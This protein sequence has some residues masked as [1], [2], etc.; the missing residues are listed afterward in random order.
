MIDAFVFAFFPMLVAFAG[1]SDLLTMKIGN[2]VSLLLCV[3]FVVL[4]IAL[5]LPASAWGNHARGLLVIFIPCFACF[6]AGWM[7]GGDAKL[8][9]AVGLWFG[10]SPELLV[11][12][13]FVAVYGCALTLFILLARHHFTVLPR[14]LAGQEWLLRLQDAKSGIPY[15]IAISAAA[16]QTYPMTVWFAYL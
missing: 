1:A 12:L 16:L 4:G 14:M 7:G 15:G 5:G 6:A 9:S 8:L 3:G 13:F 2:R 10:F 11:F